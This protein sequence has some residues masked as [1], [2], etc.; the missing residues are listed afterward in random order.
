MKPTITNQWAAP[1]TLHFSMRVC[2]AVSTSIFFVRAPLSPK[3][4][5][6]GWPSRMTAV[7]FMTART[8]SHTA[9]AVMAAARI[10]VT[11][12]TLPIELASRSAACPCSLRARLPS[13]NVSLLA[14]GHA[15]LRTP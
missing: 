6:A 5:G 1:T 2:P 13:S 15:A 7:I 11:I 8:A 14:P 10:V 12:W 9:T 3:R 4:S